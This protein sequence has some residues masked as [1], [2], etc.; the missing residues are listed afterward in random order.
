M[1]RPENLSTAIRTRRMEGMALRTLMQGHLNQ[2]KTVSDEDSL[3][4]DVLLAIAEFSS[5]PTARV[6]AQMLINN[7]EGHA[8]FSGGA[9]GDENDDEEE[10]GEPLEHWAER[11]GN[12]IDP[13]EFR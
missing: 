4:G 2:I 5:D 1:P 8:V 11:T 3:I 7:M 12:K 9:V 6:M 10:G 13:P